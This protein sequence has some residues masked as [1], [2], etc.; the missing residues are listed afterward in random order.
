M[1]YWRS[2]AWIAYAVFV[3]ACLGLFARTPRRGL[4]RD[5]CVLVMLLGPVCILHVYGGA[6]SRDIEC[7]ISYPTWCYGVD[8]GEVTQSW[9][10]A[11]YVYGVSFLV[12]L[13]STPLLSRYRRLPWSS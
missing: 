7:I 5:V 12:G 3:V 11:W 6:A 8:A 10:Y 13:V 4:W 2:S 9:R 1:H